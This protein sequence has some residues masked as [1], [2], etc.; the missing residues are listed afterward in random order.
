VLEGNAYGRAG[1]VRKAA[2]KHLE[3]NNAQS[4]NVAAA[5]EGVHCLHLLGTHV[6]WR[7]YNSPANSQL[8][9]AL[10]QLG[11]PEVRN[12]RLSLLIKENVVWL[13]ITVDDSSFVG[14]IESGREAS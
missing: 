1:L 4:V 6:G 13:Y 12:V 14:V 9:L 5:V 8:R 10:R 7:P 11:K 2:G 3:E